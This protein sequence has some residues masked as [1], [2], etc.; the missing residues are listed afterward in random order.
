MKTLIKSLAL[1]TA[2][3]TA[4]FVSQT[5]VAAPLSGTNVPTLAP[6]KLAHASFQAS[7]YS[8]TNSPVMRVAIDKAPTGS[9]DVLV[10]N[11]KGEVLFTEHVAKKQSQFRASFN[12]SELEDGT[13]RVEITNGQD[14]TTHEFTIATKTPV[15]PSRVVAML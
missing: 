14:T 6:A 1:A 13:Y 12:L 10:K 15:S 9:M 5:A 2:L 11:A 8:L 4:C 7:V 3:T